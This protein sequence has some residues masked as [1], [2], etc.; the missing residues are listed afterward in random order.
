MNNK[1]VYK[2]KQ[3]PRLKQNLPEQD[4]AKLVNK[5][6]FFQ[7]KFLK[8]YSGNTSDIVYSAV[9]VV[10]DLAYLYLVQKSL[11]SQNHEKGTNPTS[12][13]SSP[14]GFPHSVQGYTVPQIS[15]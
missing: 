4:L 11:F 12:N 5:L 6:E 1:T 14:L 8:E 7:N 13:L 10:Y 2:F 3:Y 9:P 15:F